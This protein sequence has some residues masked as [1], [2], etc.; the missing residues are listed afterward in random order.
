MAQVFD[1]LIVGAGP[2]GLALAVALRDTDLKIAIVDPHGEKTLRHAPF[3]GREIALTHFS[4]HFLEEM[5]IWQFIDDGEIFPLREAMVVNGNS[6]FKLHFTLPKTDSAKRPI[7]R[8]GYLV[9]N[10]HIRSASYVRALEQENITWFYQ[11]KA[12]RVEAGEKST[13]VWLQDGQVLEGRLLAAADSRLSGLR[14][15]MGIPCDMN[16]FGRTVLVFRLQHS[17][18]NDHNAVEGFF[19]GNTLA[20][21]PLTDHITNCVITIDSAKLAELKAKS[22]QDLAEYVAKQIDYRFGDMQLISEVFDYPLLGT[23]ARR[24]YAQRMVLVG[25]AACGMHPV[26][27]HGYNLGL[28]GV[29]V[30]SRLLLRQIGQG[31]DIGSSFLLK[32]YSRKH[33]LNTLPLYLGTNAIVALFTNE[34]T[35]ARFLRHGVLRVA[36]KMPFLKSLITRQLTG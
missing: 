30:L 13:R 10:H 21:L 8:L 6:D 15:Q 16:D 5:G 11:S 35:T 24:F 25:D 26:T 3:D 18:S 29:D 2:S 1:L 22:A 36:D 19:Y 27:A 33:R 17:L 4:K 23:H 9:S 12:E 20:L 32:E 7:D 34:K 14:R 31:L 28:Q